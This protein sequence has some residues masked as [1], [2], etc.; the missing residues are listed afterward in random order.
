MQLSSILTPY[1]SIIS[2]I[3][4]QDV[5]NVFVADTI[6]KN[7]TTEK[8]EANISYHNVSYYDLEEEMFICGGE[9]NTVIDYEEVKDGLCGYIKDSAWSYEKE[10]RLRIEIAKKKNIEAI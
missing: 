10:V 7:A 8:C 4:L 5:S 9:R 3:S 6:S 1:S 2:L